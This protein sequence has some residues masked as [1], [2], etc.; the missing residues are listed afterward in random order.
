VNAIRGSARAPAC[1]EGRGA[2]A[3]A[4]LAAL[5]LALLPTWL[6]GGAARAQGIAWQETGQRI[7]SVEV[8]I[9]G[10][11]DPK[12]EA[13]LADEVRR[14]LRLFPSGA[15]DRFFADAN[16]AKVRRLPWVA[17]A[18]YTVLPGVGS[19]VA[20]TIDVVARAEPA[21]EGAPAPAEGLLVPGGSGEF[22]TLYRR[23]DTYLKLGLSS[24]VNFN[25][26]D[27]AWYGNPDLLLSGNPLV[28]GPPGTG[29]FS[30]KSAF[31][32]LG[33]YGITPLA[34]TTYAYGGASYLV[35]GSHGQDLFEDRDRV[36]GAVED[37]YAGLVGG[38]TSARGDR[39]VWNVS[40]GR[41]KFSIG[42]GFL[43]GATSGSGGERAMINYSPRWAAENLWLAEGRWNDLK[44]QVFDVDPD[45][46]TEIDTK[47]RVRGA[48][49]ELQWNPRLLFALTHLRVPESEQSYFLPDFSRRSR[50]GL[51]VW[52][53]RGE[54]LP[55]PGQPGPVLRGE[56]ARQSHAD[57]EMRATG[58]WLQ[59]GWAFA[60]TKWSPRITYRWALLTGDDPSTRE[61]ERWDPLLMGTSPWD[62]V[63]GMNH[64]KVFGNAN[65]ISHRL[66]LEVRPRPDVQL[67]SQYWEF[68]ADELNNIGGLGVV[69]TLSSKDLGSEF[70][71]MGRWFFRRN[72]FFQ[73]QAAFTQPGP[74]LTDALGGQVDR[75][76]LFFN[77]FV[78]VSF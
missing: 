31:V 21:A 37:A 39:V 73:A 17:E 62:W 44:V 76:W 32:D 38:F 67:I 40:G 77:T 66:Q 60:T 33:L 61:Y 30:E 54:W 16:L 6:P 19:G 59:G 63:Q 51:R 13:L 74:A 36:Y 35:S 3:G 7:E 64:G 9:A 47:T 14:T 2:P 78:R 41:K 58:A 70:N 42:E 25:F 68:R 26:N 24:A 23:D 1:R 12:R 43:I 50:E 65:R 55:A 18:A 57:F 28:N 34:G 10:V 69:T 45:E 56:Y 15:F 72:A 52:G 48:N 53:G 5:A 49:V 22:P 4:A 46:L 20:I 27:H 29:S 11:G 71:V 8:R 75:P